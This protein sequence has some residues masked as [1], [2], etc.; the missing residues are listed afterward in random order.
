M[1][2]KIDVPVYETTLISTGKKVKFRPFLVKEQKL[3]LMAAQSDDSN[4]M[5]EVVKQVL[6]N[7]LVSKVNVEELP[8]FDLE[9]LFMNLRAKSVGEVIN[10]KYTCNNDVKT[11][12]GETKKCGSVVSFDVNLLEIKPEISKEHSKKIEISKKLGIMMKYPTM[13][14]LDNLSSM[15]ENNFDNLLEVVVSC[16]DYIY[17]DSQMYYAKDTEKQELIE[18]VE[19]LQQ[20]DL[21]KIQNFFT[22][23]PK[24][25]KELQFKCKKC[26]YEDKI[27][28]EGLQNFFV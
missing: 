27:V 3:F 24:N 22:T 5:V 17:D 9:N 2:P 6:N 1:L 10:L 20:E 19:N 26:G 18:F 4:E 23:M 16:I 12:E 15:D 28:V 25:K 11:D 14:M 8:T 7:C 13:R 21:V